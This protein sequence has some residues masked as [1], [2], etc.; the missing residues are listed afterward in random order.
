MLPTTENREHGWASAFRDLPTSLCFAWPETRP[1]PMLTGTLTS[2]G[3]L[4][5][6]IVIGYSLLATMHPACSLAW[7]MKHFT[8]SGLSAA[9]DPLHFD[10]HRSSSTYRYP[11]AACHVLLLA[12]S[13]FAAL[14]V[15]TRWPRS[16]ERAGSDESPRKR[17]SVRASDPKPTFSAPLVSSDLFSRMCQKSSRLGCVSHTLAR[18]LLSSPAL[19]TLAGGANEAFISTHR[20][21]IPG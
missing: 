9:S 21:K 19:C 14:S 18:R 2:T 6:I 7:D 1:D 10:N 16:V 12:A 11:Q 8:R 15:R 17:A 5:S 13:C 4:H 3:S 20:L